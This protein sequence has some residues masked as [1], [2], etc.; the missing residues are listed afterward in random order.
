MPSFTFAAFRLLTDGTLNFFQK[1]IDIYS[2]IWY[3][4]NDE[5]R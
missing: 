4:D 5:R 1:G 2:C 3:N